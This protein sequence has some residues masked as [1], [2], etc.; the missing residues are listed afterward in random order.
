MLT[1]AAASNLIFDSYQRKA[2]RLKGYD[3]H[4]RNL[5]GMRQLFERA[6]ID[7]A[8]VPAITVTGSKG[9]GSTSIAAAVLLQ[10]AGLRVGLLTSPHYFSLCE[11]V[12]VNG[13]AIPATDYARIITDMAPHIKAVD[14]ALPD[15]QY[16]SPTGLFLAVAL[17]YFAEQHVMAA[18][19]E[20][21]RGGRYDDVSMV[22]NRVA[23]FTP[24]T[25]E[26]MDKLG[27]TVADVTW[28]KTGIIKPES[29]VVSAAQSPD[30]AQQIRE[31][32]AQKN[33]RIEF[34]GT[35]NPQPPVTNP[36][37]FLRDNV[38]LATL[39]ARE[40]ITAYR[41]KSSLAGAAD[42]LRR[43]QFPGRTD[44]VSTA[45]DVWVD[46][47]INRSSAEIF[48]NS[49]INE[50]P[51]PRVLVTALPHDKDYVGLLET[52]VPHVRHV[53]VT[54]VSA[55]HLTFAADVYACARE[56]NPHAIEEPD[57]TAA[58]AR[59]LDLAGK[60]GTIW[61]AGTQSLVRDALRYWKRDL[62]A[63]IVT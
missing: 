36:G 7:L 17:R 15:N 48:L 37:L 47:A 13:R 41:M 6:G 32:A 1:E 51:M 5:T 30:V 25:A 21:G 58:F 31:V 23:C 16:L 52:L 34:I 61:C 28:H 57:V 42:V 45:P 38:A 3:Q 9:K 22:H 49:V 24:I 60:T 12:R 62:D 18:V 29:S 44:R 46:G 53:I 4:T 33:S 43:V 54:Q 35:E 56:L 20:V 55:Q 8:A 59:A 26:H 19:L 40:L 2:T 11:R 10:G 39:A 50:S 14:A 27:P 63:L